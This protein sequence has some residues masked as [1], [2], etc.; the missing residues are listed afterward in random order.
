[1]A[2]DSLNEHVF[3]PFTPTA[4]DAACT[5]GCISVYAPKELHNWSLA[6]L[7]SVLQQLEN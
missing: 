7:R 3:V 1:M 5:N 4:S 2:A 6:E